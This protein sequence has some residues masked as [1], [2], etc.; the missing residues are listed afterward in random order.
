MMNKV[1]IISS[2]TSSCSYKN[3]ENVF[4][5]CWLNTGGIIE[6]KFLSEKM[7]WE[8]DTAYFFATNSILQFCSEKW[9][10][11]SGGVLEESSHD[12]DICI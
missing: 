5:K 3:R 11:E 12:R 2:K 4:E 7:E 8:S 6:R 9:L 1:I 10:K